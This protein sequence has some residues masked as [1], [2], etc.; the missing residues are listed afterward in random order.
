MD[1]E[2]LNKVLTYEHGNG[3]FTWK[4]RGDDMFSNPSAANPWNAKHAGKVAGS[5][6]KDG[7]I[8]IRIKDKV[9]LAHR[10]AWAMHHQ[11][12]IPDGMV[13]DHVNHIKSDNRILN[14][15]VISSSSNSRNMRLSDLNTSGYHGVY[16]C[17]RR[18]KWA[19]QIKIDGLHKHLGYF[20]DIEDA[21]A[22]RR[23]AERSRGFHVNHGKTREVTAR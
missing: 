3:V 20:S 10:I 23:S 22:K 11:S 14:L 9:L 15:R 12:E 5:L 17:K 19:A 1:I 13:I 8:K 4:F 18:R 6:G 2:Y 16:F 7:Y 21:V